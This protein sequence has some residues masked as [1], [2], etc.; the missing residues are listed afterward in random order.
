MGIMDINVKRTMIVKGT[1]TARRTIN[2][3]RIKIVNN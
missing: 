1:I 3:K 2:A